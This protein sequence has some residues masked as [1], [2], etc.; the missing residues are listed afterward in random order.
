MFNH[1]A[2]NANRSVEPPLSYPGA[3]PDAELAQ[4]P[5][6][7]EPPYKPYAKQ[8]PPPGPPYKPSAKKSAL[9]E[10][11]YEPY[12]KKSAPP[13]PPYEL[14]RACS[15]LAKVSREAPPNVNRRDVKISPIILK[16]EEPN[17]P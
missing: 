8:S 12:A 1:S 3:T 5:P 17:Y 10:P 11:S 14:T 6:L 4:K 16:N 9:P 13:E 2:T 7:P 15:R